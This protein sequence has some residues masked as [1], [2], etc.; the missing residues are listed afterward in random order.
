MR[1]LRYLLLV[2]LTVVLCAGCGKK[3]KPTSPGTV[4]IYDEAKLLSAEE[5]EK[6]LTVMNRLTEYGSVVF[7][8]VSRNNATTERLAVAE[9]DKLLGTDSGILFLIDMD[10][11]EIYIET[12]GYIGSVITRGKARIITDNVYRYASKNQYYSCAEK[13]FSQTEKLLLGE[14]IPQPMMYASNAVIAVVLG[15][16]IN[17]LVLRSLN[18]KKEVSVRELSDNVRGNVRF[19]SLGVEVVSKNVTIIRS[20]GGGG[21]RGGFGGGGHH[22]HGGGH[23]F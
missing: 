22:S 21:G 12:D 11:R 5:E 9:Y 14:D 17:F 13:T 3:E 7:M 2:L 4:A 6:L 18:R 1:K 19:D 15:L 23:R 10:N 8:T 16:L 20:S